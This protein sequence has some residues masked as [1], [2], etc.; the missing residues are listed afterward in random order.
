MAPA[1]GGTPAEDG[2]RRHHTA[3]F[4]QTRFREARTA[5]RWS[6]R[7]SNKGSSRRKIGQ[8]RPRWV[9]DG[10]RGRQDTPRGPQEAAKE[11]PTMPKSIILF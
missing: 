4:L 10:P 9:Q 1:T 5:P 11:S 6:T 3:P 7:W 2:G 8:K